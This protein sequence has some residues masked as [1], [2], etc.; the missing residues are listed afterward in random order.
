[1]ELWELTLLTTTTTS[2]A[3][4]KNEIS[5][6]EK[7]FWEV[8]M[9]SAATL[10]VKNSAT[11]TTVSSATRMSAVAFNWEWL[12]VFLRQLGKRPLVDSGIETVDG[13]LAC[14]LTKTADLLY[15]NVSFIHAFRTQA[16]LL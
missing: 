6:A 11:T 3:F 7:E 15:V 13:D 4:L 16:T 8:T 9:P 1:M 12:G 10:T 2:P 5:R 14:L